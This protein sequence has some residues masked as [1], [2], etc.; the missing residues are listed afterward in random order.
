MFDS[1]TASKNAP[2]VLDGR[3]R[4]EEGPSRLVTQEIYRVGS[5]I[6]KFLGRRSLSTDCAAGINCQHAIQ[7]VIIRISAA[8]VGLHE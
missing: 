5:S 4:A 1:F 6:K 2:A 7:Y 3:G 8:G